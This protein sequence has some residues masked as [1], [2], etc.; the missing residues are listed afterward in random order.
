MRIE[1]EILHHDTTVIKCKTVYYSDNS[2]SIYLLDL[3]N[4]S[5]IEL[6]DKADKYD[7]YTTILLYGDRGASRVIEGLCKSDMAIKRHGD[8]PEM[9]G[10]STHIGAVIK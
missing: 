6:S 3:S 1:T 7:R 10:F 8:P 2:H 5:A 4:V 9:A